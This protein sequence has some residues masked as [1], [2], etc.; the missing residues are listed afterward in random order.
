MLMVHKT[1]DNRSLLLRKTKSLEIVPQSV[2]IPFHPHY[3]YPHLN[4]ANINWNF[5]QEDD[6][7]DALYVAESEYSSPLKWTERQVS[8]F[9]TRI[10][11]TLNT[12]IHL[13]FGGENKQLPRFS[14]HGYW[15]SHATIGIVRKNGFIG[16]AEHYD[17]VFRT[18]NLVLVSVVLHETAHL[19]DYHM[20]QSISH[21]PSFLCVYRNLLHSYGLMTEGMMHFFQEHIKANELLLNHISWNT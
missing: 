6:S 17:L 9:F 12:P 10:S 4:Y 1:S 16:P 7:C 14:K 13:K 18:S 5:L 20:T 11:S 19:L 8:T 3:E 2:H 15:D 21:G